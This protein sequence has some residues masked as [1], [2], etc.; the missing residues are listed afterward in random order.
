MDINQF[1]KHVKDT[2]N[3]S[4]EYQEAYKKAVMPIPAVRTVVDDL[5]NA[6]TESL[7][8]VSNIPVEMVNLLKGKSLNEAKD[9]F[10]HGDPNASEPKPLSESAQ[11]GL[12]NIGYGFAAPLEVGA[13]EGAQY[14]YGRGKN[15]VSQGI[16]Y[17]D[18]A[19]NVAR[20]QPGGLQAG[21]IRTPN[22][23]RGTKPSTAVELA[24]ERAAPPASMKGVKMQSIDDFK[25]STGGESPL[26]QE[27]RKYKSVEEFVKAK[28]MGMNPIDQQHTQRIMGILNE[29]GVPVKSPND[30]VTLYHGTNAKGMKGITESNS[31]NPSSYLATDRKAAEG[32]AFG[33]KGGVIEVKIPVSEIGAVQTSMAGKTGATVQTFGRLVKGSDGIY[34]V[35]TL[36][37]SEKALTD[38]YTQATKGSGGEIGGSTTSK[39]MD[40][41]KRIRLELTK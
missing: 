29:S 13:V 27:A 23:L 5:L 36:P 9:I 40:L 38:I 35:D 1:L 14:L 17:S 25:P 32:F 20:G 4:R 31:L 15:A 6:T 16:K 19:L 39:E 2:V 41:M 30:V 34:R 26:I 37:Y 18:E 24:A 12:E 21:Y 10:L 28:Y 7:Q 11:R 3:K 22:A 8:S 33:N